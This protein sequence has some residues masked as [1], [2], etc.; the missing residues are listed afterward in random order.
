MQELSA[1]VRP[2]RAFTISVHLRDPEFAGWGTWVDRK[3]VKVKSWHAGGIG[4]YDLEADPRAL[5]PTPFDSVHYNLPRTTL[6]AFTEDNGLPAVD[7]LMCEQGTPDPVLYHLTQM[8]LPTLDSEAGL[9]DLCFD[10]FVFMLC[11]RVVSSYSCARA[12]PDRWIGGLASWQI[13]RTRELLDQHVG[14]NLRL[15]TLADENHLSVSHF[16]RSFKRSFGSPL[17]RYLIMQRI[18]KAKELLRY[19]DSSLAGIAFQLG[20]SDQ[21][22]FS[23]AFRALV[24]T[25]PGKWR[26]QF[27]RQGPQAT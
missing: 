16:A 3:F 15:S 14:G 12:A 22:A 11:A 4:I 8:L 27:G 25:P 6:D 5:R 19:S 21:A 17:H 2:E 10:Y 24:G 7:A 13:R 1:S 9:P 18:E 23:R 20:F 26:N